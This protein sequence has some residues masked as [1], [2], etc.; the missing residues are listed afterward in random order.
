M[1]KEMK[2]GIIKF[3]LTQRMRTY[4][5][6]ERNFD[7][8]KLA[9]AIN[10]NKTQERVKLGD[11]NGYYGHMP[12]IELGVEPRE[13]SIVDGK[14]V[15]LEPCCRT[16]SLKAYDDGTVEHEQEFFDTELGRK[17]WERIQD[18]SGGF[19]SVISSRGGEYEFHGFDYVNE[20][21]YATNRPY[22]VALDGTEEDVLTH[23]VFMLDSIG[24]MA[25]SKVDVSHLMDCLEIY[26]DENKKLKAQLQLAMDSLENLQSER[27][28]LLDDIVILQ[29]KTKEEKQAKKN[30]VKNTVTLD[31]AIDEAN[32]FKRATLEK[33]E[34]NSDSTKDTTSKKQKMAIDQLMGRYYGR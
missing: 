4:N 29:E 11:L 13:S 27:D 33:V 31:K 12:R 21:N 17:A 1:A 25:D 2:T 30:Q 22:N 32:K 15:Y 10:S 18:N 19:S 16:I 5:G 34:G 26:E 23:K 9:K 7:V 24:N 20:P 3:N 8:K 28:V 14:V 6:K